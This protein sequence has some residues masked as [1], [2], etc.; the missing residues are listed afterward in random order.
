MNGSLRS[1]TMRKKHE[2]ETTRKRDAQRQRSHMG[3]FIHKRGI[4]WVISRKALPSCDDQM[5]WAITVTFSSPPRGLTM[6]A[7]SRREMK[8][9]KER[10]LHLQDRKAVLNA[11]PSPFYLEFGAGD[12]QRGAFKRLVNHLCAGAEGEQAVILG[13]DC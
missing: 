12:F 7:K 10:P 3:R 4:M 8:G 5:P 11:S 1:S 2:T 6:R 9:G 13:I